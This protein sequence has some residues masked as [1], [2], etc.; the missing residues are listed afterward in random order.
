MLYRPFTVQP[1]LTRDACDVT[2]ASCMPRHHLLHT[3]FRI[4]IFFEV[5]P[6]GVMSTQLDSS[7]GRLGYRCCMSA[8][9]K[10]IAG[11][12]LA[13]LESSSKRGLGLGIWLREKGSEFD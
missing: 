6:E 10:M 4:L 5:V 12:R 9:V 11:R 7:K 1:M 2:L 13:R 3:T 8:S